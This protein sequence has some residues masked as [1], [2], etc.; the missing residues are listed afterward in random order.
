VCE[1]LAES[2]TTT[3]YNFQLIDLFQIRV[4]KDEHTFYNHMGC[5]ISAQTNIYIL[6]DWTCCK[7]DISLPFLSIY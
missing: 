2:H 6:I 3:N 4:G 1:T 7:V 5:V